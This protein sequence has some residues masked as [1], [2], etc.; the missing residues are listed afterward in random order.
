MYSENR[1]SKGVYV[2][3]LL[4]STFIGNLYACYNSPPVAII[5]GSFVK[6]KCL[7][8]SV[9]IDG[10]YSYDP[11]YPD[12]DIVKFEWDWTNDGIYDY[13]ETPGDGMVLH[14]YESSGSYTVKLRVTDDNDLTSTDT[15]RVNIIEVISLEPDE[16]QEIDDGDDDPDTREFVV[17]V[18]S[19]GI[20]T[21]TATHNPDVGSLGGWPLPDCWSLSGGNGVDDYCRTIF[22]SIPGT[23]VIES[24]SGDSSKVTTI[25]VVEVDSIDWAPDGGGEIDDGDGNPNTRKVIVSAD[26]IGTLTITATSNPTLAEMGLTEM[27]LPDCWQLTGGN[28]SSRLTRDIS[29]SSVCLETITATCGISEKSLTIDVSLDEDGEEPQNGD[30]LPDNWEVHY[31][32]N[33]DPSIHDN[34]EDS[35]GD[36]LTNLQEYQAGLAP[37]SFDTDSDGLVD[38]ADGLILVENYPEGIDKDEDGSDGYGFIDGESDVGTEP[39]DADSDGDGMPDGWEHNYDLDPLSTESDAGGDFDNDGYLNFVEY[40]HNSIPNDGTNWPQNVTLTVPTDVDSIQLAID[41]SINGDTIIVEPGMYCEEINFKGKS[42]SLRSFDPDNQGIVETT[43]I[44]AEHSMCYPGRVINFVC[45]EEENSALSGFTITGGYVLGYG[46]DN[47]GGGIHCSNS[48]PT[49][50]NCVISNN[51]ADYYGGGMYCSD[52]AAPNITNCIFT[53]NSASYASGMY[54]N[55]S[56]PELTDCLFIG[57]FVT[58]AGSHGGM[59]NEYS[60]PV[61]NN[62]T[63]QENQGGSGCGGIYNN[64]SDPILT[65]C[66]FIRNSGGYGNMRNYESSPYILNCSFIENTSINSGGGMC[67]MGNS[68]PQLI[69]CIFSGNLAYENGGGMYNHTIGQESLILTNCTFSGNTASPYGY[70]GGIYNDSSTSP[71]LTNCIFWGNNDQDGTGESS[72]IYDASENMIVT[73]CCV[74]GLTVAGTGNIGDDPKFVSAENDNLRLLPDSPCIDVGDSSAVPQ[75]VFSDFDGEDRIIDGDGIGGAIV[76]MGADEVDVYALTMYEVSP[77]EA[78]TVS[79]EPGIHPYDQETIETIL[80]IPA[81]DYYGF[82]SWTGTAVDNNKV[83]DPA[84]PSTTV[85]VNGSYTLW[86]NFELKKHTLDISS[87][88]LGGYVYPPG[89]GDLEYV[90]G[91]VIPEI[92]AHE[93]IGHKFTVWTGSAVDDDKIPQPSE[94]VINDFVMDTGYTL[95]ANFTHTVY[96]LQVTTNTEGTVY[97]S[98]GSPVWPDVSTMFQDI[99]YNTKINLVAVA[100]AGYEFEKWDGNGASKLD[101]VNSPVISDFVMDESYTLR[102]DFVIKQHAL[103]ISSTSD[104]SVSTPWEGTQT[105]NDGETIDTIIASSVDSEHQFI[106]WSGS[107]TTALT[108]TEIINLTISDFAMDDTYAL[109]A[110]FSRKVIYVSPDGNDPDGLS[111][112]TAYNDLQSALDNTTYAAGEYEIWVASGSEGMHIYI[113]SNGTGRDKTF[114][115]LNNVPIYGGFAGYEDSLAERQPDENVTILSGDIDNDDEGWLPGSENCYHVVKAVDNATLDGFVIVGGVADDSSLGGGG[116]LINGKINVTVRN[117]SFFCNNAADDKHGGGMYINNSTITLIN[118]LFAGNTAAKFNDGTKEIEY[119]YGGGIYIYSGTTNLINCTLSNNLAGN[120]GGI[121]VDSGTVN[122]NDSILWDNCDNEG[123]DQSSQIHNNGTATL[124]YCCINEGWSSPGG[125]NIDMSPLFVNAGRWDGVALPDTILIEATV[126]DF[127]AT[128]S[129]HQYAHPDFEVSP[130]DSEIGIVGQIGADLG[131][132]NKPV[133]DEGRPQPATPTTHG[134]D[135]FNMWYNDAENYNQNCSITLLLNEEGGIYK[136]YD[137]S[138]FPIDDLLFGNEG[139]SDHNY[140][141]TL[142]LHSSFVYDGLERFFEVFQADDDLFIYINKKLVVDIGGIHG[143]QDQ[144]VE[145]IGGDI[146]VYDNS[147]KAQ[148]LDGYPLDLNLQSGVEYQF[149]LFFAERHTIESHLQFTTDIKLNTTYMG[150]DYHLLPGSPCIDAADNLVLPES[151]EDDLDGYPRF[152]DDPDTTDSGDGSAPIVDMGVYE[153]VPLTVRGS[154]DVNAGADKTLVWLEDEQELFDAAIIGGLGEEFYDKQWTVAIVPPGGTVDFYPTTPDSIEDPRT[155]LNP[156]V[157]LTLNP[158][159][160]ADYDKAEFVLKLTA[161]DGIDW[162]DDTVVITVLPG[163]NGQSP[164]QVDAGDP[165]SVD[166]ADNDLKLNGTVTDD[167]LPYGMLDMKWTVVSAMKDDGNGDFIIPMIPEVEFSDAEA[168]DP[169]TIKCPQV[170]FGQP[171]IY[172]LRLWASDGAEH[173]SDTTVVTVTAD[174]GV[175]ANNPPEVEAGSDQSITTQDIA[176][177]VTITISDAWMNDDKNPNPPAQ[178]TYSWT[179]LGPATGMILDDEGGVVTDHTAND[180]YSLPLELTCT[181][182]GTYILT[183]TA[184][185]GQYE[186]SDSV[187]IQVN[188]G[189]EVEAGENKL[190]T[191][192]GGFVNVA[193]SDAWAR[194]NNLP[195][196]NMTLE[197]TLESGSADE[198][199]FNGQKNL[200][201]PTVT[202]TETG[203]YQLKLTATDADLPIDPVFDKVWVTILDSEPSEPIKALFAGGSQQ[204]S[205]NAGGVVYRRF[206]NDTS[207]EIISPELG[208][209]VLALCEYKNNL[210]AATKG[211]YSQTG[212]DYAKSGVFVW[213]NGWDKITNDDWVSSNVESNTVLFYS[214]AVFDD[215][216]YAGTSNSSKLLEYDGT[217]WDAIN[218]STVSFGEGI[219]CLYVWNNHLYMGSKDGD[220]IGRY[221]GTNF[222]WGQDKGGSCIWDFQAYNNEIYAS[223]FFDCFYYSPDGTGEGDNLWRTILGITATNLWELEIYQYQNYDYLYVGTSENLYRYDGS[224]VVQVLNPGDTDEIIAMLSTENF[225]LVIGTGYEAAGYWA[226]GS[227]CKIYQSFDGEN[228]VDIS[229]LNSETYTEIPSTG[230]QCFAESSSKGRFSNLDLNKTVQIEQNS[231]WV[232]PSGGQCVSPIDPSKD[233]ILYTIHYDAAGKSETNLTLLDFLP[234][235]TEFISA[236]NNGTYDP[237]SHSVIWLLGNLAADTSGSIDLHVKVNQLVIPGSKLSNTCIIENEFDLIAANENTVEVCCWSGDV[238]YVDINNT[239]GHHNGVSWETAFTD[240]QQTLSYVSGSSCTYSQIWV[241]AGTYQTNSTFSLIEDIALYGG[242][243]GTESSLDDRDLSNTGN[244]SELIG[245]DKSDYVVT[246][247]DNTVLDGFTITNGQ[248]AGIYCDSTSPTIQYCKIAYNL[249]DGIVCTGSVSPTIINNWIYKNTGDGIGLNTNQAAVIQSNTIAFN[250]GWG[251]YGQGTQPTVN[252]CIIYGNTSGECDGPTPTNSYTNDPDFEEAAQNDYHLSVASPCINTGDPSYG[253]AAGE[254]DI[255]GQLRIVGGR[256]DIGADEFKPIEVYVYADTDKVVSLSK[257]P[258]TQQVYT[259]VYFDAELVIV[260]PD[261]IVGVLSETWSL[262]GGPSSGF[263]YNGQANTLKPTFIFTEVGSYLLKLTA[264]D[265]NGEKGY[266][267]VWVRV[268]LGMSLTCDLVALPGTGTLIASD[269]VG[270]TPTANTEVEWFGPSE[271]TFQTNPDTSAPF[272]TEVT[273]TGGPA[274]YQLGANVYDN[275]VFLGEKNIWVSVGHQQITVTAG[276][277]RTEITWADNRVNLTGSVWGAVPYEIT[278]SVGE[279]AV[280]LVTFGDEHNLSTWI[281]FDTWGTYEVGLVATDEWG[282]IIGSDIITITVNP[283]DFDQLIVNA[284]EDQEIT[285]PENFVF[286]TGNITGGDY[287]KVQW[288]DPSGAHITFDDSVPDNEPDD[289]V[290]AV[291]ATFAEAGEYHIQLLAIIDDTGTDVVVGVDTIVVTVNF[292]QVQVEAGEDQHLTWQAGGM[293]ADL[294]GAVVSGEYETIEWIS[295]HNSLTI[296]PGNDLAATATFTEAGEFGIALVAKDGD[297]NVLASDTVTIV[298]DYQKVLVEAGADKEITAFPYLDTIGLHGEILSGSPESVQWVLP[299]GFP[300]DGEH[301]G[302][303]TEL[304]TWMK[305]D[306]PGIYTF[307]LA[308]K[309]GGATVGWDT[310][311]VTVY[312]EGSDLEMTLI[313]DLYEITLPDDTVTLTGE[314]TNGTYST[315][316]WVYNEPADKNLLGITSESG[317]N[318]HFADVQFYY[319]GT[320]DIGLVVRDNNSNVIGFEKVTIKVN[321]QIQQDVTIT[322]SVDDSE[323]TLPVN[324]VTVTGF[325]SSGSYYLEWIDPAGKTVSI[326]PVNTDGTGSTLISTVTFD[327]VGVYKLDFVVRETNATGPIVGTVSVEITVRPSWYNEFKVDAGNDQEITFLVDD[328]VTLVGEVTGGMFDF[329]QWTF[330]GPAD[331]VQFEDA[332]YPQTSVSF[333][334]PGV[335]SLVLEA[336]LGGENGIIVGWDFVTITV[337]Q[338]EV[339]V[340]A[341]VDGKDEYCAV[342]EDNLDPILLT[343]EIFGVTNVGNLEY[344]W[345]VVSGNADA[346]SIDNSAIN[347][348]E[349]TAYFTEA[350]SYELQITA[351]YN[352]ELIGGDTVLVI[353]LDDMPIVSTGI[354][355]T[356]APNVLLPLNDAQAW[357]A[358]D[359]TPPVMQ[360]S[361]EPSAGVVI[362]NPVQFIHTGTVTFALEGT[363]TLT[364]MVVDSEGLTASD[365]VTIVVKEPAVFVDA[366]KPKTTVPYYGIPLDDVVAMPSLP[367]LTYSWTLVSDGDCWFEPSYEVKNPFV[368]CTDVGEYELELTVTDSD[369]NEYTDVVTI[370]VIADPTQDNDNPVVEMFVTQDDDPLPDP[371]C[372]EFDVTV[373]AEDK[374]LDLDAI[375]L[376]VDQDKDGE[377]EIYPPVDVQIIEGTTV[378]PTKATLFYKA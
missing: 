89:E 172:T 327:T 256:I 279:E 123:I 221:D 94:A 258:E 265:N 343:A 234:S 7:G 24:I 52:D 365:S 134:V 215:K 216:L 308:A 305:F 317:N 294:T 225:G 176:N 227:E 296:N 174:S 245:S 56:S 76:D 202:F 192:A 99:S 171:G 281:E 129:G 199:S 264:S 156:T 219:K 74:Q 39:S 228:F 266:D 114:Q 198:I 336:R 257:N 341:K 284:G 316:E 127:H 345:T 88:D 204:S 112:E 141:F 23:S 319:P 285:L 361:S 250:Q 25:H 137:S 321:P 323:I 364:L 283:P 184:D 301:H 54:N 67:N 75:N 163:R 44:N 318:P 352:A 233:E 18:N 69:N 335:Y 26:E 278:W 213:K 300:D 183:L 372:G 315:V 102:A 251:I 154:F 43:I 288:I 351:K 339:I 96:D 182:S 313:S 93:T 190:A 267:T 124:N 19:H 153:F 289:D 231:N 320:Y 369:L 98:A 85:E 337:K 232:I 230:I 71:T 200:E 269:F 248:V 100:E 194:E 121:Y 48:S 10:S 309:D 165:C 236:T 146:Y 53:E 344:E 4:L 108:L 322:A 349:A 150:G 138:F 78:G 175:L 272:D 252:N 181:R 11:D 273:F 84:S 191:L 193:M 239:S 362:T 173:N 371:V 13:E 342:Y 131:I 143:A 197:W 148:L 286:L 268:N 348:P 226:Y 297:D 293:T 177:G 242:F 92:I 358:S 328:S 306:E 368:T 377:T 333:E 287:D 144:Y 218:V 188:P 302:D 168:D 62:C 314:I 116:M 30:G 104:G 160:F 331:L 255:D 312:P 209:A 353:L 262:L 128:N 203:T 9:L 340:D 59:L 15:C 34:S 1:I 33:D 374:N 375:T 206:P 282:Y 347:G 58:W 167:G 334:R 237:V 122:I 79:P 162:L 159:Y 196:G 360:W 49:I 378:N 247:A 73:Y 118:C 101:N 55:N 37:N 46:P 275:G 151:V 90:H 220:N 14:T 217:N 330:S 235:S 298:V 20:I 295:P 359:Q 133:Y 178:L 180:D 253:L 50:S 57:N 63:F 189:P 208:D 130:Y 299:T 280:D 240:L 147:E 16:G 51:Y 119:G 166:I 277:D 207:W 310:V 36:G 244:I 27:D 45:G 187:T 65:D 185:D 111:W 149:D 214:L 179:V 254:T 195:M 229:S 241:A 105:F 291:K 357:T 17:C 29:L 223:A 324:T 77:L 338:P 222:S 326:N 332:Q 66:I 136:Y 243:A 211:D 40:L 367:G 140:H 356:V 120:G 292:E 117:C 60:S 152:L 42:I 155:D 113:P 271:V 170:T 82:L 201:N 135:W 370:T 109:H 83:D 363:Y 8:Q 346:V 86:A 81:S 270:F 125:N 366:G 355:G 311:T 38:G 3:V 290:L 303:L 304:D 158:G 64:N 110:V 12:G 87:D 169:T 47:Y 103:T 132:D 205:D 31:W 186:V 80:A 249:G 157:K 72:Q 263:S 115:L 276:A 224:S 212:T 350:G 6:N 139:D 41:F 22:Q 32:P 28:G 5:D 259:E 95:H 354:Y 261:A 164:P 325:V 329:V 161:N 70:G 376:I 91:A 142:E 307:G 246:G 210:Y 274:N 260:D 107:G 21:I 68:G 97:L 35:D 238:V 145:I 2:V 126:R 106:K 61:L 373:T